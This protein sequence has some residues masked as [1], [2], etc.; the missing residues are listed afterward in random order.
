MQGYSANRGNG[1]AFSISVFIYFP[2]AD[3]L[4]HVGFVQLAKAYT[5]HFPRKKKHCNGGHNC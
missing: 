5:S 4:A 3:A 2:D 1:G